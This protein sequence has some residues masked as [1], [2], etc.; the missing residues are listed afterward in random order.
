M[1]FPDLEKAYDRVPREKMW[2]GSRDR[3]LPKKYIRLIQNM[4]QG[5]ETKVRSV[6]GESSNLGVNVGLH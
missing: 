6:A 3:N 2:K 5:S 4:Y 1:V